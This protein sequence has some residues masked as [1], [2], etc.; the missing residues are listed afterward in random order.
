MK[1]HRSIYNLLGAAALLM[2]LNGCENLTD[3]YSKDPVNITDPEVI[4]TSRYLNGAQV[5]LIGAYEADM[6][7]LT[8]MWSGHF[9]GEDRQYIGLASYAVVGRDFNTEWATIYSG[10][11]ANDMIVKQRARTENNPR[12]LGIAQ[13]MDAMAFG[14]ATDLWG[15]VPYTEALLYPKIAKPK[16]D[17][18]ADVYA[19]VQL[20]L[21]SAKD[22]LA[23]PIVGKQNP[24]DA[25]SFFGGNG[26]AWIA[27][28]N[29]LKAR[30]YLHVKD[31]TNAI[32]Y[33]DPAIAISAPDGNLIAPHG[34]VYAQ[35][36]NLFYS[37][38][39]WDRPGYMAA[40]SYA[41]AL[42]D[43][44]NPASR[45]NSKTNEEARLWYYYIPGGGEIISADYEPNMLSAD[46]W[47]DGF[48]ATST[49]FFG[50]DSPFPMVSYEENLL[51]RAEAFAKTNASAEALDAL[52]ELRAYLST[53]NNLP[54]GYRPNAIAGS[55]VSGLWG[56]LDE[57]ENPVSLGLQYDPYD[58]TNFEP[59][60][61]ANAD[62]RATI[63]AL[64]YEI[65]EEKYITLTGQLEVFNDIRRTK[66]LIGVP[67]RS[68][69]TQFPQRLLY[70]Q[71]E[72]NSNIEN[73]PT[74]NVGLFDPTTANAS[75]Y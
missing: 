14:L 69:A 13:V 60:G 11:L 21:D 58:I 48:P 5:N 24:G 52:N 3:G 23:K 53:G 66:N 18:Q 38:L 67:V 35:N 32:A 20:L 10:V 70:A 31:Y 44:A 27:V 25:D 55:E 59:G 72:V 37:F 34:N 30:F 43:A 49:G 17:K 1:I 15:D 39:A 51:I 50:S 33:S 16:Y 64:L 75:A 46:Y 40:N 29:T 47:G 73:V 54:E 45:N 57:N 41:P 61:I 68:G 62:G 36:F 26:A 2:S 6:N 74:A 56:Y 28:A 4:P 63:D 9:S 71:D 19:A 42:L 12:I 8:G 7:R 22:N 65:L